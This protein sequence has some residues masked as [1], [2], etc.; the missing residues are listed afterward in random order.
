MLGYPRDWHWL[1]RVVLQR[2]HSHCEL[3]GQF[4]PRLQVA[5]WF[6]DL[7]VSGP[8]FLRAMCPR[9]H[10]RHDRRQH[11]SSLARRQYRALQQLGQ[12]EFDFSKRVIRPGEDV[13]GS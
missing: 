10:L 2:A 1:R 4:S 9:C 5:H 8:L 6:H 3:C 12:L 7:G 13:A 11:A